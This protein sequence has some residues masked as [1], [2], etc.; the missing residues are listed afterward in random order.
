VLS[1]ECLN[2][3]IHFVPY[4][5]TTLT[6]QLESPKQ[7][8]TFLRQFDAFV[9]DCV[10]HRQK[11]FDKLFDIMTDV[12]EK[13]TRKILTFNWNALGDSDKGP[14]FELTLDLARLQK[15][16]HHYLETHVDDLR[17]FFGR[18]LKMY[19]ERLCSCMRSIQTGTTNLNSRGR[20]A[21]KRELCTVR[22]NMDT[23][24]VQCDINPNDMNV[25]SLEEQVK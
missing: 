9:Q 6:Q 13:H 12:L 24:I 25:A 18:V 17:N 15:A 20:T 4:L 22:K 1:S 5:R 8:Q 2:C 16:V 14:L 7:H 10:D 11:I 21:L 3:L 19:V 23:W